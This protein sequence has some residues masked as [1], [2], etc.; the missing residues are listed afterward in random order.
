MASA[1]NGVVRVVLP[2]RMAS[3]CW[4]ICLAF[5]LPTA[6]MP[7]Y[8]GPPWRMRSARL[9][10]VMWPACIRR[11]AKW[12]DSQACTS[13]VGYGVA[14]VV[15]VRSRC[16]RIFTTRWR[17]HSRRCSVSRAAVLPWA[18]GNSAS[19]ISSCSASLQPSKLLARINSARLGRLAK[20]GA[21]RIFSR[22]RTRSGGS[23]SRQPASL[24]GALSR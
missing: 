13:S 18:G 2:G 24:P 4:Q 9:P 1:S 8:Q 11:V 22:M 21:W 3:I 10:I 14:V 19:Y 23:A 20:A 7:A 16:L 17:L 6:P 5:V 15:P 12:S